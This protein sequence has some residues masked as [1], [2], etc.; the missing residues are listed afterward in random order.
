[1]R[2]LAEVR[3]TTR[4]R[5]LRS[6]LTEQMMRRGPSG[7][8]LARRH[9]DGSAF[10]GATA[11]GYRWATQALAEGWRLLGDTTSALAL[12]QFAPFDAGSVSDPSEMYRLSI[13]CSDAIETVNSDP[14]SARA[15]LARARKLVGSQK[16]AQEQATLGSTAV[17]GEVDLLSC[18]TRVGLAVRD[19]DATVWALDH[20]LDHIK[21]LLTHSG[22]PDVGTTADILLTLRRVREAGPEYA[23]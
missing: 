19:P 20:L 21:P 13:A 5:T 16:A 9:R 11:Y 1:M 22:R 17:A 14:A 18:L 2:Y 7:Y 12:A 15:V 3:D 23:R 10:E 4:F 8:E 6:F